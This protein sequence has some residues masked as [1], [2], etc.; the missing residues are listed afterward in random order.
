MFLTFLPPNLIGRDLKVAFAGNRLPVAL[1]GGNAQG[2]QSGTIFIVCAQRGYGRAGGCRGDQAIGLQRD[3]AAHNAAIHRELHRLDGCAA[4]WS[5]VPPGE[6][7]K[8]GVFDVKSGAPGV[9]L[10]GSKYGDW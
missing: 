5:T 10:D 1:R 2:M 8:G 7:G 9:A 4:T 6:A 3:A